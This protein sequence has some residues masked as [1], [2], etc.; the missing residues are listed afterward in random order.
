LSPADRVVVDWRISEYELVDD[1][2]IIDNEASH[3][4]KPVLIYVELGVERPDQSQ[5]ID[6]R[7]DVV[8]PGGMRTTT[9]SC[10]SGPG[11]MPSLEKAGTG[12]TEGG[13]HVQTDTSDVDVPLF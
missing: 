12:S 6:V 8:D 10:Q 4:A 9:R 2:L 3:V 11:G 1:K 5:G 7:A 13:Q